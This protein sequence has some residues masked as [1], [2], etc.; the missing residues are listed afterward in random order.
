MYGCTTTNPTSQSWSCRAIGNQ[1]CVNISDIDAQPSI[2]AHS[3]ANPTLYGAQ[4]ANSWDRSK[5]LSVTNDKAP[6]RERDQTMHIVFAPYIDVQGDYHERSEI[7]AVMR[8]AQWWII[9]PKPITQASEPK[10]REKTAPPLSQ[11]QKK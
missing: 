2:D 8:K 5:A 10:A 6:Q 3:E 11:S 7:Y 1:S 4:L 9:P